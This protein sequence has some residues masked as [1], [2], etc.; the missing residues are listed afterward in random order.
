MDTA[1]RE[2]ADVFQWGAHTCTQK[3]SNSVGKKKKKTKKAK[4][5]HSN[6][7]FIEKE[8]VVSWKREQKKKNNVTKVTTIV[9]I[10]L[11]ITICA[12]SIY[13]ILSGKNKNKCLICPVVKKNVHVF[14]CL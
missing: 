2:G 14:I 11:L 8:R 1:C 4:Q 10:T 9:Q 6:A 13:R 3:E 5:K 7:E 12:L